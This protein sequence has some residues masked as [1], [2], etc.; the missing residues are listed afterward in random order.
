MLMTWIF[1]TFLLSTLF[2]NEILMKLLFKSKIIINSIDH[3][4]QMKDFSAI[5]YEAAYISVKIPVS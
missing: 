1:A 4:N 2:S 3:L 5:T